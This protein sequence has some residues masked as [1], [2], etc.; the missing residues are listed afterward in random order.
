VHVLLTVPNGFAEC[1]SADFLLDLNC[2][3][4]KEKC[5][6]TMLMLFISCDAKLLKLLTRL[7]LSLK[8][9]LRKLRI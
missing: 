4:W 1:S 8:K 3:D 7:P 6:A 5:W 9:K 2:Y